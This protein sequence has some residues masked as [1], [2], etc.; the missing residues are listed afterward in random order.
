[1]PG[2]PLT[3]PNWAPTIVDTIDRV[4]GKVRSTATDNAV[5]ASRAV[6]FGT[7]ALLAALVALPLVVILVLGVI[8]ELLGFFVDHGTA[9][10]L[11]YFVLGVILLI[12]G[13]VALS[14]RHKGEA[15]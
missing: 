15:A 12:G 5:K 7:L 3:D 2:N 11:S 6:V 1:M 10:Y 13:F 14:M 4:V 9:V 8:R